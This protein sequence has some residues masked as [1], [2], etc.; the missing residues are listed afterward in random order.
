MRCKAL[1]ERI[2][3]NGMIASAHYTA[4]IQITGIDPEKEAQLTGLKI[5]VDSGEYISEQGHNPILIGQSLAEKMNVKPGSKVVVTFTDEDGNILSSA[6]KVKGFYHAISSQ[7]EKMQVFVRNS[8]LRK[9]LGH[10]DATHEFA[11]FL[12]NPEQVSAFKESTEKRL[13]QP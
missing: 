6:F 2:L 5:K 9:L 7:Q 12:K 1:A 13:P 3:I 10:T 4:G 8:D 11:L